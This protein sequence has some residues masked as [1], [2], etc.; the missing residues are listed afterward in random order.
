MEE[1]RTGW[2]WFKEKR[3]FR[4]LRGRGM[5]GIE[6]TGRRSEVLGV[7]REV[8]EFSEPETM[9]EGGEGDLGRR[10]R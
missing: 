8:V 9:C 6:A 10:G 5:C 2:I 3:S 7:V 1:R 4:E